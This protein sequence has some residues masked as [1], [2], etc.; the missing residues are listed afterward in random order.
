MICNTKRQNKEHLRLSVVLFTSK[1]EY[2]DKS[3][4]AQGMLL[5][6]DLYTDILLWILKDTRILNP[7]HQTQNWTQEMGTVYPRLPGKPEK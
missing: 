7:T 5:K 6:K 4:P 2:Q 1:S 3:S